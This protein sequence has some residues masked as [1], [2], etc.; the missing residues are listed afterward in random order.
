MRIVRLPPE[1]LDELEPLWT[2]LVGHQYA[3]T[4][5]LSDRARPLPDTWR[6]RRELERRWLEEEPRSFVL[7]AEL[8]GALAGYAFVRLVATNTSAT[9]AMSEPHAELATL[10]VA[11]DV[12]GRGIGRELMRAVHEELRRIGV[13]DLTFGV[14]TTNSDAIRFYEREGAVPFV[15]VFLQRVE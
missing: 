10:S 14:I 13:R 2:A 6:D 7:A 3:L 11:P 12:R 5:H 1:R 9:V 8:E 15:T 4:P